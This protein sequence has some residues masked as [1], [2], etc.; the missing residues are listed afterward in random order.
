LN[1][2]TNLLP[3]SGYSSIYQEMD[4]LSQKLEANNFYF[5]ISDLNRVTFVSDPNHIETKQLKNKYEIQRKKLKEIFSK[6]DWFE[7]TLLQLMS[8]G[9]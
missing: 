5:P 7:Q 2:Q 1:L 9:I 8:D 6:D 3:T 4:A